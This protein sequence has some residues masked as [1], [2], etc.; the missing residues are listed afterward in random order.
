MVIL[1][2]IAFFLREAE[3]E[4]T[5]TPMVGYFRSK[6]FDPE[7]NN[8]CPRRRLDPQGKGNA[9]TSKA[10]VHPLLKD[11]EEESDPDPRMVSTSNHPDAF[12][13]CRECLGYWVH[14]H[15]PYA[16]QWMSE[17]SMA[18]ET[19]MRSKFTWKR[20]CRACLGKLFHRNWEDSGRVYG[21]DEWTTG[22]R[23][24]GDQ[25]W[26]YVGSHIRPTTYPTHPRVMGSVNIYL[27]DL[28]FG[29]RVT[30][31][32]QNMH[33]YFTPERPHLHFG[34]EREWEKELKKMQTGPPPPAP[35]PLSALCKGFA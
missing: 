20:E 7:T 13:L 34:Y 18:L 10:R 16:R 19:P 9:P 15:T 4:G 2:F 28:K 17:Q 12:W 8:P 27:P 29:S 35:M 24:N 14:S 6:S 21:M 30:H 22:A 11:L 23:K 32:Q 33:L 31:I 1:P 26:W 5:P 25:W 3:I